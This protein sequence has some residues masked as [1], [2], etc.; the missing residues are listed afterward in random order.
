MGSGCAQAPS[1]KDRNERV[2]MKTANQRVFAFPYES[3]W[4]AAQ[5]ALKYP[6]A[7]NNM[8]NGLL[9]TDW[10]KGA[11][12]FQPPEAGKEPSAG[13]RYKISMALVKGRLDGRE[14]VRVTIFKR[15]EKQ[16]D[17]FS[18]PESLDSDGLEERVLFYRIERELLI[19]EGLKKAAKLQ[20]L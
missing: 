13:V 16:R 12:G 5:L 2:V 14:S 6:I 3:V 15:M 20:K 19:D 9:E 11:D 17:F 7:I 18:E 8:D 4:R 1:K 10:I